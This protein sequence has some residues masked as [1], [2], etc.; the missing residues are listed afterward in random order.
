MKKGC[1]SHISPSGGTGRNEGFH[2]VLNKTLKKSR[3]GIQLAVALLGVFFY[4][5]NE[6]QLSG[7]K[8]KKTIRVVPPIES[9]FERPENSHLNGHEVFGLVDYSHL[10]GAETC[11]NDADDVTEANSPGDMMSKLNE[12]LNGEHL[13]DSSSDDGD[14]YSY[15]AKDSPVKSQLPFAESQKRTLIDYSRS[16]EELCSYVESAGKFEKFQPKHVLF[17]KSGLTLLNSDLPSKRQSSS[18]DGVL[19]NYNMARVNIPGNG[20]CFFQS[21]AHAI[22]NTIIPNQTISREVINHLDSLGLLDVGNDICGKL[23]NLVVDE[24]LTNPDQY[25]PFLT[26]EQTFETEARLFLNDGHFATQLGNSM[27]LV[28]ANVLKHPVVVVT[29]MENL[30]VL[31]VT[32]RESI[33]C[34]PIFV[35]FDQS[36]A[37]HY[38]AVVQIPR[39]EPSSEVQKPT[40]EKTESNCCR[41]GQGVKKKEKGNTSCDQFKKRCK[42]F[43]ALKGCTEKCQCLGCENPHGKKINQNQKTNSS[44]GTRKRRAADM[45]TG[46]MSGKEF[47][48]KRPGPNTNIC[49]WTFLEELVLVQ[50]L[51]SQFSNSDID[52]ASIHVQ[53]QQLVDNAEIHPKTFHQVTGKV[54]SHLNDNEVFQTLLKEQI[55]L[56]W[57]M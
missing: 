33:Q 2:R 13:S 34:L 47:M 42:C 38:D 16:M 11:A 28:M 54:V 41:C 43:Q 27:P 56:N 32:P 17:A 21:V 44:T 3:I 46:C 15:C 53:Y 37:G 40:V 19:A 7:D 55:R 10:S 18:L 29:E 14:M 22:E 31:P 1:L 39:F 9:H 50:L 5:W 20:N 24:W 51:Q 45:T 12:C 57:F 35:A 36:G 25:K 52:M 6:K 48:A 23:R 4:T 49:Q 8:T 26:G 30:P